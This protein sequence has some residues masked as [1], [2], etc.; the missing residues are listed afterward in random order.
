MSNKEPLRLW[1]TLVL[2]ALFVVLSPLLLAILVVWLVAA[3]VLYV[4]VWILWCTRGRDVL[5]VYSDSPVWHDYVEEQILPR[6]E[7]RA[8]TLNWSNR[9]NWLHKWALAPCVF[10]FFG[11]RRE[12]N[13]LALHFRPLRV[14]RRFQFWK[15]FR[16]YKHGR[17]E[18]LKKVEQEFFRSIE[19][20]V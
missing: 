18:S 12:Y 9:R 15:A 11:G 7:S 14:H 2:A 1:Q 19:R 6:I 10:R 8:I 16:D 4:L 17:T 5:F 20:Y 3:V 13:P